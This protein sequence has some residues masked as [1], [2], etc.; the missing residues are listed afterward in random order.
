MNI[1]TLTKN[2]L[3]DYAETLGI[4]LGSR[5]TVEEMR[6]KINS[7]AAMSGQAPLQDADVMTEILDK[8]GSNPDEM[9]KCMILPGADGDMTNAFLSINGKAMSIPRNKEVTVP[10]KYI[11]MAIKECFGYRVIQERNE[12]TG[13]LATKRIKVPAYNIQIL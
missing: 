10:K 8:K 9:I 13:K 2:E 7:V 12:I 3:R 4:E 5:D 11:D 1:E 6:A